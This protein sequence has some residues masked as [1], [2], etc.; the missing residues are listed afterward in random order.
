MINNKI[1]DIYLD[2]IWPE[3]VAWCL[4]NKF[5]PIYHF[6]FSEFDG[7]TRRLAIGDWTPAFQKKINAFLATKKIISTNQQRESYLSYVTDYCVD[8][9][10]DNHVTLYKI[11]QEIAEN[12]S[13][14]FAIGYALFEEK[15]G[16]FTY[17]ATIEF[18][19]G[20]IEDANLVRLVYADILS[21]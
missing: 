18:V 13:Q 19:F 8:I 10:F 6:R 9:T 11:L 20:T 16:G 5:D 1:D 7:L 2:F 12:Y 14:D 4:K 3:Y 21:N 15:L 17:P